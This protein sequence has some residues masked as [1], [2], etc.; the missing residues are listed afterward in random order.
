MRG[1]RPFIRISL[2][3]RV[4]L[5]SWLVYLSHFSGG[6]YKMPKGETFV[7]ILDYGAEEPKSRALRY[8]ISGVALA[9][10]IAAGL[11]YVLRYTTEKHTVERLMHAVV[12][13]DSQTDY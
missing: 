2:C 11:W 6:R 10:L 4:F 3:W 5:L 8:V 1:S 12:A 13:G 7:G 9:L